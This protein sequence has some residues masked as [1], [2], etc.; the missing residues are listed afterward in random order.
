MFH[1][2]MWLRD[3]NSNNNNNDDDYSKNS[4]LKQDWIT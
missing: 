2:N 4:N 1:F 3:S